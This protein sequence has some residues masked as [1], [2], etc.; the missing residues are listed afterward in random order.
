MRVACMCCV[1]VCGVGC[2]YRKYIYSSNIHDRH[3]PLLLRKAMAKAYVQYRYGS[4][5]IGSSE[6]APL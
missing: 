1:S 6:L 3:L 2:L 4:D 5:S